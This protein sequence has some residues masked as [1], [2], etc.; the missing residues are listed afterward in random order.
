MAKIVIICPRLP[1]ALA[2]WEPKLRA[3]LDRLA[4]DNLPPTPP[5]V[6]S[7]DGVVVGALALTPA[8]QVRGASLCLG[9][10]E[11]DAEW[12]RAGQPLP[13]VAHAAF[14]CGPAA[15]EVLTG[16]VA[17]RTVWR[18]RDDE[19]FIASTSQRAIISLLGSFEP[20]PEAASWMLSAGNL[21]PACGWDRRLTR[22][23]GGETWRLDRAAW[24][25]TSTLEEVVFAAEHRSEEGH[26]AA[27]REA[28]EETF[29]TMQLDYAH[30]VLPLSGG[31]DSRAILCLLPHT[32][33]LRAIT[34]GTTAALGRPGTDASVARALAETLG[35]QHEYHTL[36]TS[37]EPPPRIAERFLH[38]GEGRVDHI[39]GYA[40]GLALWAGLRE[41]GIE[42]IIRGDEGF[43]W[44]PAASARKVRAS[45][46]LTRCTDLADLER[47]PELGLAEQTLPEALARRP[48][49]SLATWRDRLYLQFRIPT[50]LGGLTD[51]KTPYVEVVC[52][53]LSRRILR[54]SARIP[55]HLRTEKR[56]FRSLVYSLSPPI[57]IAEHPATDS[58]RGI[59]R[60]PEMVE[61]MSEEL[62][63]SQAEL[64]IPRELTAP[65]VGRLQFSS[66]APAEAQRPAATRGL[67]SRLPEPIREWLR[68][69]G[70][71]VVKPSLDPHGLAFRAYIVCRMHA[72]LAEDAKA[73]AE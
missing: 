39:G 20:N 14:R 61:A 12:W 46:G 67:L 18:Y 6:W 41:R 54:A 55:D 29:G 36:D 58:A 37:D 47:A 16:A 19:V 7:Q 51:L 31:H 35:V 72:L 62:L 11:A 42:G 22:L 68:E 63:S 26:A 10:P 25:L 9:G 33:G 24:K 44:T 64:L 28:L 5:Q 50:V 2:G 65:L 52:P 48:R 4:P 8:V 53:L 70:R 60:E 69:R 32:D 1:D 38:C 30:W 13:D 71:A 56:L 17:P 27:L 21:G 59:L 15:L 34:W 43:G 40:D 45:V 66:G 73:G 3:A 57:P 49:E 23:Q